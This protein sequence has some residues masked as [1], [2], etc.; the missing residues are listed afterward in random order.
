MLA[1]SAAKIEKRGSVA[2]ERR[3][4]L[5]RSVALGAVMILPVFTGCTGFFPPVNNGGGGTGATGN[6]VYVLNQTTKSVSG[7][8]VGTGTLTAVGLIAS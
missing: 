2:M 1:V 4:R 3:G 6:Q 7:F 5:R 8:V